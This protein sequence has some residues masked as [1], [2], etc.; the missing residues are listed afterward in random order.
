MPNAAF[1]HKYLVCVYLIFSIKL[2]IDRL[3]LSV[4]N[5]SPIVP[6][7]PNKISFG[8]TK[9]STSSSSAILIV[10]SLDNSSAI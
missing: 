9:F 6:V 3:I 4:G 1:I 10:S 2:G 8:L 7:D 5:V